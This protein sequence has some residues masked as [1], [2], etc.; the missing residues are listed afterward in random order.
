MEI[1]ARG[2]MNVAILCVL[3]LIVNM[4]QGIA[5]SA[6]G[7]ESNPI[8]LA[9]GK[10]VTYS[11]VE[12]G[13]A[14]D[15]WKYPQFVGEMV[16]DGN[17]STRWSGEK[18][19]DQWLI[20]DLGKVQEVNEIVIDFHAVSPDYEV[21]VSQDGTQYESIYKVTDGP[22]GT[23]IGITEITFDRQSVRYI[24]YQQYKQWLHS[25]GVRYFGSSIRELEVYNKYANE[26]PSVPSK[27]LLEIRLNEAKG[28]QAVQYTE[29]SYALLQDSIQKAEYVFVHA[30]AEQAE[31][32]EAIQSL[33]EAIDQ[34]KTKRAE[35]NENL[36]LGKPVTYSGVEGGKTGANWK[37]PQF[38]GEKTVDGDL[39][40]RWSADKADDQWLIVDLGAGVEVSVIKLSFHAISP[41]YEVFV[42]PDGNQYESVYKVTNGRAGAIS[43]IKEIIFN[44]QP[45]R[46]IK[47]QQYKQWTHSD[48]IRTFGSSIYEIEAYKDRPVTAEN[49]LETA[50]EQALKLSGDGKKLILPTVHDDYQISLFGSDTKEIIAMDGS[51]YQPLVAMD[52][53]VLYKVEN[54]YDPSDFATSEADINIVIPGQY[55][56]EAGDNL[57]PPVLPGLR[58][59]KGHTGSFTITESSRIVVVDDTLNETA[60]TIQ[61]YFKSM[62]N[63]DIQID[64]GM[65]QQGDIVLALD[66]KQAILGEEGYTLDIDDKIVISSSQAKG[67]LYGGISITQILYQD[68]DHSSVPKG[69]ARDYPK[70]EVRAGMI[71]VGRMYIPLEYIQEMSIY[72]AWFK[73][74][75]VQIHVNDYWGTSGYSAFRLESTK[76]PQIVSQ[77]GYYTKEEYKQYQI[78]MKKFGIDVV[79]EID[80]PYHSEVFRAIPGVKML[81][82][83]SLDIRDAHTVNIVL[84]LL[85]EYLDGEDPVIQ[86]KKFHVG[87]DEYDKAYSE[88]MRAYTDKLIK[89]VNGKGYETRIWGELG[90]RGYNGKTPVTNQATMNIWS[91]AR[92]DVK[93]MYEAGYDIINTDGGWLYIVPGS[94]ANF[95]DRLNLT[96]LYNNFDVNNF[97]DPKYTAGTAIMPMAHPQTKGAEFAIWNDMT[98][99]GGGFSEF[100]VFDRMKPAVA[101]VAEK[102]WYGEKTEGQTAEQFLKRV[103]ALYHTAG[104]ANPGRYVRSDGDVIAKYTFDELDGGYSKDGSPNRYDAQVV[105]GILD[106]GTDNN[107]IAL[108]GDGYISLPF[109]SVGFPYTVSLDINL[110]EIPENTELFSGKDGSLY[111]NMNGTG[112][113]GFKRGE[114]G[115]AYEFLFDYELPAGEWVNIELAQ[116]L[117]YRTG[118]S[119]S[120]TSMTKLYVNGES[121]GVAES[122]KEPINNIRYSSS[123]VLPTEK[124]MNQAMGRID[125]LTITRTTGEDRDNRRENLA[126][127]K[128]TS[129]SSVYPDS[130]RTGDKAVDGTDK[131]LSSRWSSKKATGLGSNE[132]SGLH[133]SKEQWISVDLGHPYTL[134]EVYISWEAA[135]AKLFKLQGSLDGIE[136]FDMKEITEFTGGKITISDIGGR[137][138]QY[139]RVFAMEPF[140]AGWGYSIYEIEAYAADK[141]K[142]AKTIETATKRLEETVQGDEPGQYPRSAREA[143][144]AAIALAKKL[145]ENKLATQEAVDEVVVALNHAIEAYNTSE[146]PGMEKP[147]TPTA[148]DVSIT[149]PAVNAAVGQTLITIST[150]LEFR[151]IGESNAEKQAWTSGTGEAQKTLATP[152][153]VAGDK[154]EVRVK[155][156]DSTPASGIYTYK[157]VAD[158]IGTA[159][160]VVTPPVTIPGSKPEGE[161]TL[162]PGQSGTV[163]LNKEMTIAIPS[164][165]TGK[166]L[167]LVLKKITDPSALVRNQDELISS[168]IEVSNNL[169]DEL[170][171]PATVT[172][173]FDSSKLAAGTK[174]SLFIYDESEKEWIEIGGDVSGNTVTAQVD[175]FGTFAVFVVKSIDDSNE[176]TFVDVTKHWAEES[177]QQ[178]VV[179]GFVNGYPDG[180]FRPN[181]EITRAEF[182]VMLTKALKLQGSDQVLNFS[183]QADIGQ[184]ARQAIAQ[185]VEA[186]I[187]NG[188]TDGTFR[189]NAKISRTEMVLMAVRA[190]KLNAEAVE[191]TSFKDDSDIPQWAKASVEAAIKEGLVNGIGA[192]RFAPNHTATRAESVTLLLKAIE[193]RS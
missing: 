151:I 153:L 99:F 52:V 176:V 33:V 77:D 3:L 96:N 62:L 59:W 61:M 143:L 186:G 125:N 180:T 178:A 7:G 103:E 6:E 65:A 123:F 139:I 184:W 78:D 172:V 117:T 36:A 112:K 42:S 37:Y 13:K 75:E 2:K 190:L 104:G 66:G 154:I 105:N 25:D 189:P 97:E 183:D 129:T 160:T 182:I 50:E 64:T 41:D 174:A 135:Y 152:V 95:P 55:V 98:S 87:T 102:T 44:R 164:E 185:A 158:D 23:N 10:S 48:G 83:G 16:V 73:L 124:I 88:E 93:E 80:T 168:V 4:F 106:K 122:T 57:V 19:D 72:M 53:N 40:T 175:R 177:I 107:G 145:I 166:T 181:A 192:N 173:N 70:Y 118:S 128:P 58:E 108:N 84:D 85:D 89:Y 79:T 116:E 43:E 138:V 81:K 38:A 68:K 109:D 157:V 165:S 8:N 76:Y 121:V 74:N 14:G 94:N 126:L 100:D 9:L 141:S 51:V 90:T 82:R 11:G 120:N 130:T 150:A 179:L 132:D 35:S 30:D 54:K 147:D 28:Y 17:A 91:P 140:N 32:D 26:A 134:S 24:K 115:I 144:E 170:K 56:Q 187:I 163:S 127:H 131:D 29:E 67:V 101:I 15:N 167:H 47:Y 20:I 149:R 142:L 171:K 63:K 191:Q 31:I 137:P 39:A 188:Y 71:D 119:E 46:Y 34:L 92:S 5:I 69:F 162:A 161:L 21:F 133:G 156:T 18:I 45:V 12:G 114:L 86:S 49:V 113:L 155:E 136:Y 111:A 146:V 22:E 193:R 148:K 169:T 27:E 60:Q 110:S 1:R 159:A